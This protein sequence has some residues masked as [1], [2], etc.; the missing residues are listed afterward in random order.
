MGLNETDSPSQPEYSTV[1]KEHTTRSIQRLLTKIEQCETLLPANDQIQI[2]HTLDYAFKFPDLWVLIKNLLITA[3]PHMEQAG[4]RDQWIPYL[5]QG[6]HLSN[7]LNDTRAAAELNFQLGVLYQLQGDYETARIHFNVSATLFEQLNK[8][9][10]RASALNRLAYV[11]RQQRQF[12]EAD[13]LVATAFQ[14]KPEISEQAYGYYVLGLIALDNRSWQKSAE[15]AQRAFNLWSTENNW[16]MMGRSLICLGAAQRAM[17]LYPEAIQSYQK[18]NELFESI[19]DTL[20]RAVTQMN[21]GNVYLFLKQPDQALPLLHLAERIFRK[22]QD[23]FH[24]AHIHHNIGFAYRQL[25]K[26][27]NAETA[28]LKS[29]EYRQK[30]G[31]IRWQ[32]NT[33]DGL[34]LTYL[35][36]GHPQKAMITFEA[37]LQQLTK[38][39]NDPNYS[40]LLEMVSSN[41]RNAKNQL[42]K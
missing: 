35:G 6:H 33:L 12:D 4:H 21:Q 2:R 26:W 40:H 16:R 31:N 13:Q 9:K 1:F 15:Y 17:Q 42:K 23:G 8:P 25:E 7:S 18:A 32:V 30:L 29:L 24:L 41:L 27:D 20:Y 11:A 22:V 38:I 36:R 37:A 3:A 39:K 28:Y 34:G 14:L 19:Q 5:K 10:Y